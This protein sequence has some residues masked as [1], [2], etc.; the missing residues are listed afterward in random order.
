M[1]LTR[2][3]L[4]LQAFPAASHDAWRG[5]ACIARPTPAQLLL[6]PVQVSCPALTLQPVVVHSAEMVPRKPLLHAV[7]KTHVW[8]NLVALHSNLHVSRS[9]FGTSVMPLF[10]KHRSVAAA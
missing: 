8:P 4:G 10:V 9:R 7:V 2:T 3:L 6:S 1:R 5:A